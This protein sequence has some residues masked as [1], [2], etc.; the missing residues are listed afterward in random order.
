MFKLRIMQHTYN[1]V[2]K[3][4]RSIFMR[5]IKYTLT[6]YIDYNEYHSR[7]KTQKNNA[8]FTLISAI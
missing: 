1:R 7:K 4:R 8:W 3:T 5:E 2:L 6:V